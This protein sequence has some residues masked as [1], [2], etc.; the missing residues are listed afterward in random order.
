MTKKDYKLIAA[1][2]A[3]VR[4]NAATDDNHERGDHMRL[5]AAHIAANLARAL[6]ADN[7]RFDPVTFLLACGI[8][9]EDILTD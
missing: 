5:G 4:L 7:P 8:A 1:Q 6:R 2:I 3:R 9:R